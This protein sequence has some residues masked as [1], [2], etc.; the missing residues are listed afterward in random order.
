MAERGLLKLLKRTHTPQLRGLISAAGSPHEDPKRQEHAPLAVIIF[1]NHCF[2]ER[3]AT[4]HGDRLGKWAYTVPT[5][6]LYIVRVAATTHP[7]RALDSTI[8]VVQSLEL[9]QFAVSY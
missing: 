6:A 5:L 9:S 7:Q 1:D 8:L 2:N 3:I 4:S